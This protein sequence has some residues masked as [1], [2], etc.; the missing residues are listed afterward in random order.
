MSA[1]RL[2]SNHTLKLQPQR[3]SSQLFRR[4]ASSSVAEGSFTARRGLYAS[5]L[6][7]S[8][9]ALAAYY[10]DSRA[11]IHRYVLTPVIRH[12]L[13]AENGHKL[14]VRVLASGFAPRDTQS[15]DER[16][17]VQLWEDELSNPIGLAA[18]F[19]K[20]G[21][22]VDGLFNLGF[23]WVE[24]G[25]VT[26]KPQ[27]GNARPRMFHL[28]D[29]TAVINRYGFPSDG[30][31]TVLARLR[32]RFPI[33]YQEGSEPHASLRSNALLAVNLGKNKT[34]PVESAD[35]FVSGIR[36]FG[37]YA[38]VLVV[39]ISSPNTPGLRALQSH[40]L[41]EDLLG[42]VTH[43][44]DE[45]A[46]SESNK[47]R[48]PKLVLKIAPDLDEAQ[49]DDIAKAILQKSV[50][51]VIVSNTTVRRPSTLTDA[52]KAEAGGLSGPPLK[53]YSLATLRM[54]RARLPAAVPIIGCGGISSGA[55][56]LEYAKAGATAVQIY[57]SFGYDGVGTCRRI[58]DELAEALSREGAT[59]METVQRASAELSLKPED[60]SAHTSIAQLTKEA[61]ELMRLVDELGERVG[62][63]DPSKDNSATES[64]GV[65]PVVSNGT[66]RSDFVLF[67][68]AN[69]RQWVIL[70]RSDNAA[71]PCIF[72][73]LAYE[74]IDQGA[75]VASSNSKGRT[76]SGTLMYRRGQ[77]LERIP[78]HAEASEKLY[79]DY[80]IKPTG[81]K[82]K[83][84]IWAIA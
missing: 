38:D 30:H 11:A 72:A 48:R 32:A 41:L 60:R 71:S 45:I 43:A 1:V 22:A 19:D 49:V 68:M 59:W 16:L 29:D 80:K 36:A 58:K 18:G 69:A 2:I 12:I 42:R 25:S 84:L 7:L 61:E 77:L 78:R 5:L 74:A 3:S 6:L 26:P 27:P 44:L 66:E 64:T 10:F 52:N 76:I 83:K 46:T 63:A 33:F 67:S 82:D 4:H 53:P 14:A 54:L 23:S 37:S 75:Q 34:S 17:K 47:S 62:G 73:T 50:D 8:T 57:T 51:G 65:L 28:M 81:D 24:I 56:A 79:L 21:E 31:A 55:D 9:G 35:D 40:A 70:D 20:H 15:D 39:N 13:D